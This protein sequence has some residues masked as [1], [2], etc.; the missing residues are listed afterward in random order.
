MFT[1]MIVNITIVKVTLIRNSL[2]VRVRVGFLF[3]KVYVLGASASVFCF[4]S[5]IALSIDSIFSTVIH[6]IG[7]YTLR[8]LRDV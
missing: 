8:E 7:L 4:I 6:R 2:I 5:L 3:N 1:L